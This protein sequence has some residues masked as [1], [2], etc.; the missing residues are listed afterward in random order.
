M[1]A[2]VVPPFLA[3]LPVW[4]HADPLAFSEFFAKAYEPAARER[5]LAGVAEHED[6]LKQ[7]GFLGYGLLWV[8]DPTTGEVAGF[9]NIVIQRSHIPGVLD[10]ILKGAAVHRRSRGEKV[11]ELSHGRAGESGLGP[12]GFVYLARTLKGSPSIDC[13]LTIYA[14]PNPTMYIKFAVAYRDPANDAAVRRDL[15]AVMHNTALVEQ[16]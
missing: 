4:P 9:G 14:M 13:L 1:T 15:F 6:T 10:D 5:V 7:S 16:E 3:D 8:P 2:S 12:V 11:H